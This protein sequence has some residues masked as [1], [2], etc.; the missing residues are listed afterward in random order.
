MAAVSNAPVSCP[1]LLRTLQRD[2]PRRTII[3]QGMGLHHRGG[4][5]PPGPLAGTVVVGALGLIIPIT[6]SVALLVMDEKPLARY[7]AVMVLW[8][9]AFLSYFTI[10]AGGVD[11]WFVDPTP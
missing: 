9:A 6:F 11:A 1:E 7:A 10:I 2:A 4:L 3:A 8:L 5:D